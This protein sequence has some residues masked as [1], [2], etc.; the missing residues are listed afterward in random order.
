MITYEYG[1]ALKRIE[2]SELSQLR[3]WRNDPAIWFWCRQHDL[4][5]ES[6]QLEWY[7]KQRKDSATQMYSIWTPGGEHVGV[8]GLTSMDLINRRAE[9]SIYIAPSHQNRKYAQAA[10]KTLIQHGFLNYGLN[11]IYGES[12]EDNPGHSVFEK[13][14]FRKEG[15]RRGFY[16]RNGHYIDAH[17]FS[18]LRCEWD[19][20]FLY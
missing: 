15:V 14:G 16:Y 18:L 7:E 5:H 1:V 17:L 6:D 10:L 11:H 19:A 13:L 9:F 4:I 12:F 20:H 3:E 2:P 8:C